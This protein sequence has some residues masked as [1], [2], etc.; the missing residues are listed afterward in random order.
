MSMEIR[1]QEQTRVKEINEINKSNNQN[2][3][4]R[5][6]R[7]T[8]LSQS[9]LI[10]DISKS[11]QLKNNVI[12][13][14]VDVNLAPGTIVYIIRSTSKK[15]SR[16]RA[17][18]L[19]YIG[20]NKY[21]IRLE[22]DSGKLFRARID[23]LTLD[24]SDS[25]FENEPIDVDIQRL[26]GTSK[27][28]ILEDIKGLMGEDSFT[29]GGSFAKMLCC[30]E[31]GVAYRVPRDIDLYIPQ[32]MWKWREKVNR[33]GKT[34][35]GLPLELHKG[36]S[37]TDSR[38][39]LNV[40]ELLKFELIKLSEEPC[41]WNSLCEFLHIDEGTVSFDY[42][43]IHSIVENICAINEK[44]M[45]DLNSKD[46]SQGEEALAPSL[47]PSFLGIPI[48]DLFEE[49]QDQHVREKEIWAKALNDILH[50]YSAL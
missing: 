4:I 36:S 26:K 46:P 38:Q 23:Q 45:L 34:Y 1:E 7:L 14:M 32:A 30:R 43:L 11:S 8:T 29:I 12:Q 35:C 21:R 5:D 37:Y 19:G 24:D 41:I 49:S 42:S 16:S 9:K 15:F 44:I 20:L 39:I 13:C 17:R 48:P 27:D 40:S 10:R 3:N 2:F 31:K 47:N 25:K 50:L 18:I 33:P 22:D 6:N 28:Q